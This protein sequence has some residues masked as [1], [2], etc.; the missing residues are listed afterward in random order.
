MVWGD[1]TSMEKELFAR[2]QEIF[3]GMVDN[4]DQN[5]ELRDELERMGEWEKP[6]SFHIR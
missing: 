2:Y 6:L 3:A 1:L 4:V 5:F